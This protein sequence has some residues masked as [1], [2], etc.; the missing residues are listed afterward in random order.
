MIWRAVESKGSMIGILDVGCWM[1]DIRTWTRLKSRLKSRLKWGIGDD[2][3][4]M[5]EITSQ[6]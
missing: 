2:D 3:A 1:W 5:A 6:R 4:K